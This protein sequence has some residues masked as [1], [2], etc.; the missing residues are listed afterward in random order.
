[1]NTDPQK[2]E[3]SQTMNLLMGHG[4]DAMKIAEALGLPKYTRRFTLD[5]TVG[6]AAVVTVELEKYI[7][8]DTATVE[9]LTS[10]FER[11][12]LVK[13]EDEPG[14]EGSADEVQP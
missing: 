11:Y 10:V 3:P 9:G 5:M 4:P 13:I 6:E 1:M 7:E 12:Q 2:D 14:D 8:G